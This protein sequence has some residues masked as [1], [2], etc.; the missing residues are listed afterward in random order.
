MASNTR[1][2]RRP[3]VSNTQL[4]VASLSNIE[5]LLLAQ[6]V[7]EVGANAWSNVSKILSKHPLI[8]RPKSF[9]NAQVGSYLSSAQAGGSA[10]ALFHRHVM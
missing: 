8:S 7:H 5:R 6:C 2:G 4:D 9:F 3:A 1:S 10:N